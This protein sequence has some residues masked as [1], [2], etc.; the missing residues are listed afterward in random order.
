MILS[1]F[2]CIVVSP[3]LDR[4]DRVTPKFKHFSDRAESPSLLALAAALIAH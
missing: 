2:F 1:V 3:R 4:G